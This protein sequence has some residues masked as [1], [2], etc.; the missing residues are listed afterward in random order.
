MSSDHA[1]V[2]LD[3]KSSFLIKLKEKSSGVLAI[4]YA[5]HSAA[6]SAKLSCEKIPDVDCVIKG[7]LSF[8]NASPKRT[9]I[10]RNIVEELGDVFH[11]IPS[12]AET[13]WL[14]RSRCISDSRITTSVDQFFCFGF[15]I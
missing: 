15:Y 6:T 11:K 2:M 13:R 3:T 5:C 9:A 14:I 7:L 12:H 8:L 10:Y 4:G 1:Q